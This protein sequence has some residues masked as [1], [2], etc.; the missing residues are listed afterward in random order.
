MSKAGTLET[1]ARH[2]GLALE[3]LQD[4]LAPDKVTQFFAE[5]GLEFPPQL[6]QPGFVGALN[7]SSSTSAGLPDLIAKLSTGIDADD[8]AAILQAGAQLIGQISAALSSLTQIGSELSAI[9]G[10]IPGMN[11]AEVTS[12]ANALPAKILGYSFISY[13][14]K[15]EPG[16]IGTA[17][18]GGI[19]DYVPH[20][21]VAGDPTHPAY[22]ERQLQLSRL[23]GLLANPM[24]LFGTLYQWGQPGFDGTQ[25]IPRLNASLNLLGLSSRV[26]GASLDTFLFSL[27]PAPPG[28]SA[29]LRSPVPTGFDIL[30]PL[31]AMWSGRVQVHGAFTPGVQAT[32]TPPAAVAFKPPSGRLDGQLAV[33]LVARAP[34][35]AH[36]LVL[37]GQTGGS[38]LQTTGIDLGTGLSLAW[39][40]GSGSATAEPAFHLDVTRGQAVIDLSSGD[41]FIAGLV[42]GGNLSA[43]LDFKLHWSPRTGASVEGSSAI[44]IAIPTHITI[45]PIDLQRLYLKL[46]LAADGSLPAELSAAFQ[47]SLGP[48]QAS[49]DR[50]GVIATTTFPDHGGNL[51]PA[52]LAFAFKPPS[53]VGLS[54]D[55]GIVKGGGFLYIDTDRGEYAGALE[56][57]FAD[58]LSLHA[59]GLITTKMPDGSSGFS[60]LIII[61]ADFGPGIQLGFGFTLLAVGGLLGLNRA[62][63]LQPLMEGVRTGAVDSIMF[64]QD[65][66]AN[67]PR[68]ISDLRAIFP[69]QQ[70]TFLIGPM[71]KLGWGEPTLISLSLGV[72]IEIPGDIAILGVLKLALPT[73]DEALVL[74]QVNF[75]GAIE[76]DKDRLY[77]FAS[78]F[79]SRVLFI[80]IDGEMGVLFGFGQGAN[81]VVSVG[82]FH[83]Q[84]N[85]PPLPFPTPRRIQVD[86]INESYARIRCD[87]Y[88]AVTS[89]TAQFGSR[90][91]FF[92]GFDA[93][94]VSG[95]ASFDALLQFSPF[96]FIVDISTSFSVDVFGVG[97]Y[98]VDIDVSLEGPARWHA[99]GTASISFL[100]FSIGIGIDVS[101]GDSRDTTLPPI[102]VMPILAGELGKQ[103]NWRAVLPTSAN[104]LVSLR[105]LDPA[106]AE[107]VLHPVG[108]LQISQR[109][110]PLDLTLDKVGNQKPSDANRFSLAVAS[111]ALAKIRNLQEPFAPAQFKNYDDAAK[112]SLQAYSPQ[113]SGI[114]LSAAGANLASATAITRVVRYDLTVIDTKFRQ[115]LRRFFTLPSGLFFHFLKGA[116]VTRCVF[117]Q[118][119]ENLV[120]PFAEKVTVGPE[121]F[122]VA[123][124][125][126]NSVYHPAATSFT[127]QASA[128]DYLERTVA[129]DPT[130]AGTLHVL[131]A[132][133]VAA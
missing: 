46:G 49:V 28:L 37:A 100:F 125:S 73:E 26:Q 69:P 6:L 131:P 50:I 103:S 66:V 128:Q 7:G 11:P 82:G 56:L 21:G 130:L 98:G 133:E 12:F 61:T 113:D 41:G 97:V 71:A 36:P 86:I 48:L 91:E 76:F 123:H 27:Q 13:V 39:D 34:D 95:H 79:D 104:L 17:N 68:I 77:F 81:F 132:F 99:H 80:T 20:D 3:P 96:H 102:A 83:P 105:H 115:Y 31:S 127:S 58:F 84:Y 90:A 2:I 106:E 70:G 111:A 60:L 53:G 74:I 35:P 108:T 32:I 42:G 24:G 9:A 16:V 110:I 25:L 117:S 101:W 112:L 107:L 85:P 87:G 92:F 15:I 129:A 124:Q 72:I 44:E 116:S 1:L 62:V 51:G 65:V 120:Q 19:L 121:T 5:L 118:H 45:G 54:V 43:N 22:V 52:N 94:N 64:P 122:A 55:A 63:L 114:E 33:D 126:N 38:V 14:E 4:E 23:G 18:L 88:F 57:M 78:L 10:T 119:R 29:T 93:L 47:A 30:I 8:E 89:D 75:A 59:I 67:A 109:A 40:A